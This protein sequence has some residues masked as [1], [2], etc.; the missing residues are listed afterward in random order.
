[1]LTYLQVIISGY[2]A[3]SETL[4]QQGQAFQSR[5]E[6]KLWHGVFLKAVEEDA[7]STIGSESWVKLSMIRH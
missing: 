5:P 7:P 6:F 1:L 3:I 2:N 4:V